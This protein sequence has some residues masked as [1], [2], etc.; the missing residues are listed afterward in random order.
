M[1]FR[2]CS[3]QSA[4]NLRLSVCSSVRSHIWGT[5]HPY[6]IEFSVYVARGRR[7]VF[8][9]SVATLPILRYFWFCGCFHVCLQSA[10]QR[11]RKWVVC[12]SDSQGATPNRQSSPS[13]RLPCWKRFNISHNLLF[14]VYSVS[15]RWQEN[16]FSLCVGYLVDAKSNECTLYFAEMR[17][18]S[19]FP[20]P[21]D[22]MCTCG[23]FLTSRTDLL[24]PDSYF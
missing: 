14:T 11:W 23:D 16:S 5:T 8:S 22:D 12:S 15:K 21:N 7:S 13:L 1:T 17:T 20:T 6:F 3:R 18:L 2:R 19:D 9:G 4:S 24:T 10:R